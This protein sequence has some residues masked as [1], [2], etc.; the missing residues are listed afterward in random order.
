MITMNLFSWFVLIRR[1]RKSIATNS[2]DTDGG[3]NFSSVDA[4]Q[5]V[6]VFDT[7]GIGTPTCALLRAFAANNTACFWIRT[8]F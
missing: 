3:N 2:S 6:D 7:T 8:F 4:S 5:T 1:L